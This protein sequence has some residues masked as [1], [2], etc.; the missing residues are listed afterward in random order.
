MKTT[1]TIY[2]IGDQFLLS[3][4]NLFNKVKEQIDEFFINNLKSSVEL[5]GNFPFESLQTDLANVQNIG[6]V[7]IPVHDFMIVDQNNQSIDTD[8]KILID[9]S[10]SIQEGIEDGKG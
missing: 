10:L 7:I 2:K 3:R 1:T 4:Q 8:V 5:E 9:L 6:S